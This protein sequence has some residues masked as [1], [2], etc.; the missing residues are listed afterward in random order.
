ML[1]GE[2][3][4]ADQAFLFRIPT[5]ED[6]GALG[7]PSAFQQLSDSMHRLQLRGRSA[8][9]IDR[10]IHP[11]ITMVAGDHPLVGKLRAANHANDVPDGDELIVQ[12]DR[13]M[14]LRRSWSHV[15]G[16]W[17]R[18]LPTTRRLRSAQVRHDGR[19]VAV[20]QRS[21]GNGRQV[22]GFVRRDA[23]ACG[24]IRNRSNTRRSRVAGIAKQVLHRAAL[25]AGIGTPRPFGILVALEVA[26]VPGIGVDDDPG[27][28]VL[29]CQKRLHP[30]KVLAIADD[31]DLALHVDSQLLQ[32]LEVVGPTVVRI[33]HFG[34]DVAGRRI[35]IERRK[36]AGIVLERI[37]A[38][39]ARAKGHALQHPA[40]QPCP[41]G[42]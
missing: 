29:R 34:S 13:Q 18:A 16:E 20:R 2:L 11:G 14:H 36:D 23:L 28:A 27:R 41:P 31:D 3:G 33:N 19:R 8:V 24:Q 9:G 4:R 42:R 12:L 26:I 40:A 1:L 32:L 21:H 6:Q 35:F 17:Q 7:T 30:A 5:G 38:S 37:V 15:I 25:D 22:G 39:L 10:A